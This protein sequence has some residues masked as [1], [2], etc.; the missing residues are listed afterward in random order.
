MRQ[1][2]V[3]AAHPSPSPASSS[4]HEDRDGDLARLVPG[5]FITD[6]SIVL[7]KLCEASKTSQTMKP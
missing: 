7:V 2:P 4:T 6:N 5:G 1:Q 3:P